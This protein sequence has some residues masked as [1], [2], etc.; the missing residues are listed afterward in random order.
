M[1]WLPNGDEMEIVRQACRRLLRLRKNRYVEE[2]REKMMLKALHSV[3][4]MKK[5]MDHVTTKTSAG[6]N[7]PT[8]ILQLTMKYAMNYNDLAHA[9][10]LENKFNNAIVELRKGMM[11]GEGDYV[12][13]YKLALAY[14]L[15]FNTVKVDPLRA[16]WYLQRA[17]SLQPLWF[18]L[19]PKLQLQLILLQPQPQLQIAAM[20]PAPQSPPFVGKSSYPVCTDLIQC[21]LQVQLESRPLTERE[22]NWLIY[23][24]L[25]S[26]YRDRKLFDPSAPIPENDYNRHGRDHQIC[27]TS[28]ITEIRNRWF[29]PD[30]DWLTMALEGNAVA[31]T[32]F[33]EHQRELAK[34][35][36]EQGNK[37]PV[38]PSVT[39]TIDVAVNVNGA[40]NAATTVV[41]VVDA[42]E[43]IK[44]RERLSAAAVRHE[45]L[46]RN[47]LKR[48]GLQG[49]FHAAYLS[50]LHYWGNRQARGYRPRRA[51]FWHRR[52]FEN[53]DI[54]F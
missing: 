6:D 28:E 34:S 31:Q 36:R 20:K 5:L 52:H 22:S 15:G 13:C 51:L 46:A 44:K 18:A 19:Q 47:F 14:L 37:L 29:C 2:E 43:N 35:C 32:Y 39:P 27:E 54:K 16:R 30:K 38:T 7:L 33:A 24:Y 41:T 10:E 42:I 3:A 23:N 25:K 12:V 50:Y 17:H 1:K 21:D 11:C 9:Y 49:E 53:L 48:A 26:C 40:N 45:D 8:T 4:K